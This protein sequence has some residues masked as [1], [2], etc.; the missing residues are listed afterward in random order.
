MRNKTISKTKSTRGALL[1]MAPGDIISFSMAQVRL[2]YI[3]A[4][5]STLKRDI[6]YRYSVNVNDE[7][8]S[9]LVT[10]IQ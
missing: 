10:R 3:R 4:L 2:S 5:A 6:R 7:D 8:D 9:I 1:L